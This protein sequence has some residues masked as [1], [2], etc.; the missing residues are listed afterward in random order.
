MAETYSYPQTVS[1]LI[2]PSEGAPWQS[3]Y[4]PVN[5][6]PGMFGFAGNLDTYE[7]WCATARAWRSPAWADGSAPFT[8]QAQFNS[9][10]YIPT[11]V[12]AATGMN[13]NTTPPSGFALFVNTNMTGQYPDRPS[14]QQDSPWANWIICRDTADFTLAPAQSGTVLQISHNL[15]AGF[16]GGRNTVQVTTNVQGS[17]INTDPRLNQ[18]SAGAF[19]ANGL[20]NVGGTG[21]ADPTETRGT[22]YGMYPQAVLYGPHGNFNGATNWFGCVGMEVDVGVE[23]GASVFNKSG[24]YVAT[25]A[26]DRVAGVGHD[27]AYGIATLGSTVGWRIGYSVGQL[28]GSAGIIINPT[29]GALFGIETMYYGTPSGPKFALQQSKF[30]FNISEWVATD[31]AFLAPGFRVDGDGALYQGGGKISYAG[32]QFKL[33]NPGSIVTAAVLSGASTLNTGN[34]IGDRFYDRTYHGIYEAATIDSDGSVLTFNILKPSFTTAAVPSTT[35]HLIG[36][37]GGSQDVA[38]SVTWTASTG[39][40]IGESGGFTRFGSGTWA[41]NGA[42]AV[43][44]TAVAPAGASATVQEWFVVR[45]ASNVARYIPAF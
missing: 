34:R 4:R 15:N 9:G 35:L 39:I 16:G 19:F 22:V 20:V 6:W 24:M 41:A 40:Y 27:W 1:Q 8:G 30:G 5:P 2:P 25:L 36:G 42:V 14:G 3:T 29:T 13:P 33:D 26:I 7:F 38:I 18:W 43:A 45:N 31:S 10:V 28:S 12:S 11:N 37:S 32:N 44:L 17:T 23:S 21:L